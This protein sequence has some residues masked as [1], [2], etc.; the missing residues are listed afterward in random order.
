MLRTKKF[1]F[2][3]IFVATKKRTIFITLYYIIAFVS[4]SH[5][6]VGLVFFLLLLTKSNKWDKFLMEGT[7]YQ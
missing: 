7:K 6:S 5:M 1:L 4:F 2:N 3:L